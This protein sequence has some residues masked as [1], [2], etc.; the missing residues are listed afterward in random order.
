MRPPLLA[1]RAPAAL[2]ST[3][4][5]AGLVS[6][7]VPTPAA[8]AA[9]ADRYARQ[10]VKATNHARVDHDLDRLR[11]NACLKRKA[12][13]HARDMARQERMFHQELGPVQQDCGMGWVGEN[14]AYGYDSGRSVVRQGWMKSAGHRANI[15]SGNYRLV[16]VGA[17]KGDD[18]RWYAAQVFGTR[19]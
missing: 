11:V 12:R 9:P 14:V 15:L 16:A 18:G 2:L 17:A 19:S 5:A 13:S 6:G 3:V 10:A 4:L 7:L 8:Q 1:F